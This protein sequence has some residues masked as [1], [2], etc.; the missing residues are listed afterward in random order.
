MKNWVN[1][2]HLPLTVSLI[3][4]CSSS[5]SVFLFVRK[6]NSKYIFWNCHLEIRKWNE[7]SSYIVQ[8]QQRILRYFVNL[9][10]LLSVPMWENTMR[11]NDKTAMQPE[12]FC[13]VLGLRQTSKQ[14]SWSCAIFSSCFFQ[15]LG[16]MGL[17]KNLAQFAKAK[18]AL[19]G[20]GDVGEL[21]QMGGCLWRVLNRA[22]ERGPW[23]TQGLCGWVRVFPKWFSR[24][25]AHSQ[26]PPLSHPGDRVPVNRPIQEPRM[27]NCLVSGGS[28]CSLADGSS[29]AGLG[30][31]GWVGAWTE[32]AKEATA[33]WA[34]SAVD[35]APQLA[36]AEV[37]V[38]LLL[39]L[40]LLI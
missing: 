12:F 10:T 24:K 6:R 15:G 31:P 14:I 28:R 29:A 25:V 4:S 2:F 32:S 13:R 37:L 7:I 1:A 9:I 39:L 8:F 19:P 3:S 21:A 18:P 5:Q 17:G 34:G 11:D 30:R 23:V 22:W 38:T 33:Q 20:L 27:L 40:L 16:E 26:W 35:G 36:S